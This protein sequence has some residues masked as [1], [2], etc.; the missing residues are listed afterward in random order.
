MATA[1]ILN[2][3]SQ[4]QPDPNE[5]TTALLRVL[6]Y[7]IDNTTFGGDA[8]TLPQWTGPPEAI[9]TVL[10]LLY[11]SLST[12]FL[13]GFLAI[14]GK[15]WLNRY[16]SIGVRGSA[17][18]RSQNRQRK[19][20]GAVSWSLDVA[21]ESLPLMLQASL[22]L[23]GCAL[24]RYLWDIDTTV[25]AVL[26]AT[27]SFGVLLYLF[28]VIAGVTSDS[29]PY[30]TPAAFILRRAPGSLRK[31]FTRIF[32]RSNVY[33]SSVA[34][35]TGV[36]RLPALRVIGNTLAYPFVL[37][38]AL[39]VDLV[40][41]VHATFRFLVG[42]IHWAHSRPLATHH[43]PDRVLDDKTTKLDLR[44]SFW[45]L[46]TSDNAIKVSTL[47]FL[48]TI[49]SLAGP[50]STVNSAVLMRCFNIFSGCFVTRDDG[51]TV[52][53]RGSEQLAGASALCFLRAFSSLSI[54]D[55]RSP[56]IGD[57]RQRYREV[58]PSRVDLCGLPCPTIVSAI[59]H[60]FAE[61]QDR[62]EIIWSRYCPTVD[63]LIPFSRALAQTAQLEYHRGGDQPRVPQWLIRFALR[64]L[65][66][67][68]L[69][70]TSVVVDCLTIIATDLGCTLPD[71]NRMILGE[72]YVYHSKTF[73]S[74]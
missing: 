34:W 62:T 61:P 52:V 43:I 67:A 41:I 8:P 48:G 17:I 38:F 31:G 9:T 27:T 22:L 60:L 20:D 37:L 15:Q 57:V 69:P 64:F 16:A 44:C 63:E 45:M 74:S 36:S 30:Q 68:P 59:H 25:A 55:P 12:S 19:L 28:I 51:V 14:L 47:N 50:N 1:F 10:C 58:F 65:S 49:L 32:R 18:E 72:K 7:K 71:N 54:A 40:T 29:C 66:Q 21:L 70:P 56:L 42:F 26:I 13:A 23:M 6:I 5:E 24:S 4:L 35:W 53:T 33:D 39:I 11:A 46:H 73:V 3:Q 2:I